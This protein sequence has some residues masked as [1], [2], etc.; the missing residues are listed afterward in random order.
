M[1]GEITCNFLLSRRIF[2]F[3]KPRNQFPTKHYFHC[4][5]QEEAEKNLFAVKNITGTMSSLNG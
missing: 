4:L 5:L 3:I 1:S 2:K